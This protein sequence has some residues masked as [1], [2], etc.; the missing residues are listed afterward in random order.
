MCGILCVF[1][2]CFGASL[3]VDFLHPYIYISFRLANLCFAVLTT[4]S[5]PFFLVTNAS[6]YSKEIKGRKI[7]EATYNRT[8]FAL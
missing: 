1:E 2:N 4:E 8:C 7:L 6:E 5:L 3:Y